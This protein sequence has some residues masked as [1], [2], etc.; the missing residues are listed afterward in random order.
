MSFSCPL[1]LMYYASE[2]T[3]QACK[4]LLDMIA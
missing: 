4:G 2:G 3:G 1:M